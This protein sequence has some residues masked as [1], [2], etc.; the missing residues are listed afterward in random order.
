MMTNEIFT[1]ELRVRTYE[2][3]SL[4]HVNNAV[5]VQW[6]Q[7]LTLDAAKAARLSEPS[8]VWW[9]QA[10]AIEYHAPARD[11]DLLTLATWVLASDHKP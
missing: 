8:A 2:C 5:Y 9:P 10:L 6:L 1:D 3:D 7:Q 4:G 11:G